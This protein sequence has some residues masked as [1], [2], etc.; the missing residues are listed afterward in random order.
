VSRLLL[1][2]LVTL[3]AVAAAPVA[4]GLSGN[5]DVAATV[6]RTTLVEWF[7]D[8][9]R[10]AS[11]ERRAKA[12]VPPDFLGDPE[13]IARGA[14]RY[15]GTCSA[16]HGAPGVDPEPFASEMDPVPPD[17]RRVRLPPTEAFWV[18]K[19]GI[20]RSGMPAFGAHHSDHELWS[21]I[22]LLRRLPEMSTDDYAGLVADRTP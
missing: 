22:A 7:L 20:G 2:V 4:L 6:G 13:V 11:V 14:S 8:A 1:T 19:H 21:I 9:S 17:L 12:V 3:L 16:C 15:A 18:V 5:V 10:R